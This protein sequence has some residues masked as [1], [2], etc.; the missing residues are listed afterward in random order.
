M[1]FSFSL[2]SSEKI[3]EEGILC[4]TRREHTRKKRGHWQKIGSERYGIDSF[5]HHHA[6]H[7]IQLF[8]QQQKKY[9]RGSLEKIWTSPFLSERRRGKS[10]LRCNM[11][12]ATPKKS[13]TVVKALLF[14][15]E[16]YMLQLESR[17][18]MLTLQWFATKL[19]QPDKR[20][21]TPHFL[22]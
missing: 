1:K 11:L 3:P 15:R 4:P 19:D 8:F 16:M 5:A 17:T 14:P 12:R 9:R 7:F 2:P 13:T 20:L 21:N 6:P 22:C 18:H 10:I